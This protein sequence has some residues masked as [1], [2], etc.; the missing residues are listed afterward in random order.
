[1]IWNHSVVNVWPEVIQNP[2]STKY[3]V[4]IRATSA[5]RIFKVRFGIPAD[6]LLLRR[7]I[8]YSSWFYTVKK[9]STIFYLLMA[10][11][12]ISKWTLAFF[13]RKSNSICQIYFPRPKPSIHEV[14]SNSLKKQNTYWYWTRLNFTQNV[15]D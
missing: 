12:V 3:S 10:E 9:P 7:T 1:M 8:I 13:D 4:Q 2:G 6:V 11:S 15:Q 14:Y 5:Y